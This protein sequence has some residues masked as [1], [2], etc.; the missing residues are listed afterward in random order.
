MLEAYREHVAERQ[1][2]NLPPLP[3]SAE[4][5][6]ELIELIKNPPAGEAEFLMELLVNRVPPGVDQAAYV[7]AAF[8]ADV[9]KGNTACELI[10]QVRAT[11]LLGT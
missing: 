5:V 3:L 11:E 8:L 1:S 6:A 9:A 4:Q 2:E 10:S 7:K